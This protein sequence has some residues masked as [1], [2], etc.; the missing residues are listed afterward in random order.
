MHEMNDKTKE[1]LEEKFVDNFG[2]TI[3]QFERL[4]FEVQEEIIKKVLILNKKM[5]KKQSRLHFKRKFGEIFT[6]YPIFTKT[7]DKEKKLS[8][9]KKK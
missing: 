7:K 5:K 4:D 1:I 6:Y 3:D 2:M 8:I 9:F